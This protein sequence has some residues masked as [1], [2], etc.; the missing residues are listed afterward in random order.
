M[1]QRRAYTDAMRGPRFRSPPVP[2]RVL[3]GLLVVGSLCGVMFVVLPSDQP[4][5]KVMD[6]VA[7]I[8]YTVMALL[9]WFALPRIPNQWGLDLAVWFTSLS[10][11]AAVAFIDLPEGRVLTGFELVLF[12][13]FVA[14]FLPMPRFVLSFVVMAIGFGVAVL[15]VGEPIPLAYYVIIIVITASVSTFVAVLVS[16]LREQATTDA[17]TGALNRRGLEL[18]TEYLRRD[19]NTAV[20]LVD[21]NGFKQFNDRYGHLAG[22]QRLVE[23]ANSLRAA[24]R[25]TDLI[26][27]FGGDE[28]TVVLP[29]RT[30]DRAQALMDNA[31]G[32]PAAFSIG[33]TAWA[34]AEPL[35]KALQRADEH[36]YEA[37]ARR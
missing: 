18:T 23:V 20:A 25:H 27:R 34:P 10:T 36:L 9:V 6:G 13:V 5:L 16:R 11:F 2:F 7:A 35:A 22:D 30:V 15:V 8:L 19:E 3:S 28:F 26:A 31:A 32:T 14:Y 4:Y 33:V 29:G 21:L 24:L 17:L 12:A 1:V 37:K